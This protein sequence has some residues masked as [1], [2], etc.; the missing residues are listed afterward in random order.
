VGIGLL[1]G[2]IAFVTEAMSTKIL[3][4]LFGMKKDLIKLGPA[5]SFFLGG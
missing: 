4:R 3:I 1:L 5:G 2:L